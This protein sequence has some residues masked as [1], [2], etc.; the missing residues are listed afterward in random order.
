V[1]RF[2]LPI[3]DDRL[4]MP[5][6]HLPQC[7]YSE[8]AKR[9]YMLM[10]K[11]GW[12]GYYLQRTSNIRNSLIAAVVWN[13]P[14]DSWSKWQ[15]QSVL[16]QLFFPLLSLNLK[17]INLICFFSR[18]SQPRKS[19]SVLTWIK[20]IRDVAT[21]PDEVRLH[22]LCNISDRDAALILSQCH[23]FDL[24]LQKI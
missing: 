14:K 23:Y 13:K 15:K 11:C 4:W 1:W 16:H 8:V 17:D 9:H 3:T 12:A 22:Y 5:V 7:L 6:I 18:W 20:S 24:L 21:H 2:R 19:R 10:M